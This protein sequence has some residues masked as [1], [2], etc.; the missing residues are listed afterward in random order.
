MILQKKYILFFIVISNIM[1]ASHIS[2]L[3]ILHLSFHKGCIREIEIVAEALELKVTSLFIPDLQPKEF[4]GY[5]AGNS[6]YNIGHDR[7]ENIWNKH[8]DYFN[9]FDAIITSDTAPLARI[10]LQNNYTK[11]LIIWIC[12][13]FDYADYG[14][15]DC[16]F[17]DEEYYQ[18]FQQTQNKKNVH[19][20]PYTAFESLYA[21]Q[22]NVFF[23]HETIKPS[24]I[25]TTFNITSAIPHHIK[26]S[27][28]F[29][30]PPYLNDT[31][32][33]TAEECAL[34][35]INTYHGRYNGPNDLKEF[36][37]II[38]IP[39]AW[40][41]VAFFENMQLGIAYFIPSITFMLNNLN[42]G[43]IWWPNGNYFKNN[44]HLSE[45]YNDEYKE[46]IT[47]F[48]SWKD[49]KN[50]INTTNFNTLQAKIKLYA[51]NHRIATIEKWNQIFQQ[52]KNYH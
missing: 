6:L 34:L 29:F 49:L 17:P 36:K 35:E 28:T 31:S 27:N 4:D 25:F 5:S 39:Y 32:M 19:I 41:N 50:K 30:I 20:I 7:A 52:I 13:R 38:H 48:D 33:H 2:S 22:K 14:S 26:K 16:N 47:Y 44:Y 46:I 43:K 10:F 9:Q 37:G 51:D 23:N 42:T 8:K 24:G 11:P 45:W 12:N 18:L 40:S 1:H 21:S 3:N 15:L